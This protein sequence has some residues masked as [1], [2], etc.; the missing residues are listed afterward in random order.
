M[1]RLNLMRKIQIQ[2]PFFTALPE[3]WQ[4]RVPTKIVLH[5]KLYRPVPGPVHKIRVAR[6]GVALRTVVDPSGEV[7]VILR[8]GSLFPVQSGTYRVLEWLKVV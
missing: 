8:D 5:E 4:G 7:S 2:H 6:P 1:L 3:D